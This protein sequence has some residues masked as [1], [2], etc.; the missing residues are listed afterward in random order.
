MSR[1]PRF[2]Q[3]VYRLSG[4]VPSRCRGSR[5][6]RGLTGVRESARL[7]SLF[8]VAAVWFSLIE[9]LFEWIRD[10][11]WSHHWE[12]SLFPLIFSIK[13]SQACTLAIY[14]RTSVLPI[15][16]NLDYGPIATVEAIARKRGG[17][18]GSSGRLQS[19]H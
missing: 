19:V 3:D 13:I 15:G 5:T 9:T 10:I 17:H 7:P 14:L 6:C 2:I 12:N 11:Q 8:L 16:V 1:L 4:A 18:L